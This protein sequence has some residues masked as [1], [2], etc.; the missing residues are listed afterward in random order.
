MCEA[1]G[2]AF[3]DVYKLNR[4]REQHSTERNFKCSQCDKC[5]TTKRYAQK[6]E[7]T[8]SSERPYQCSTCGDF[9][10]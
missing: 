1:C 2:K 3:T 10:K 4:H 5:F 7:L 6:H 8:H 9:Y